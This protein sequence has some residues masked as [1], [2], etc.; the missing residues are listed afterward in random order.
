MS[1]ILA[2][3]E[4]F[5]EQKRQTEF[6]MIHAEVK[7]TAIIHIW[8]SIIQ[9]NLNF[10]YIQNLGLADHGYPNSIKQCCLFIQHRKI[11]VANFYKCGTAKNIL[12]E[13]C[14][15]LVSYKLY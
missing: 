5:I 12:L 1:E 6:F 3:Q 13:F 4:V 2:D 8:R 9:V 7:I 14:I 11:N 15:F 10:H